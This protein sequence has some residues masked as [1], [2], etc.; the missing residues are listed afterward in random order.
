MAVTTTLNTSYGSQ[1]VVGGGGFFLNNEM[2][3]FSLKPGVRSASGGVGGV[4]NSIEPGKRM[5]S[6]MSPT[7]VLKDG[8]LFMVLGS[9]G[10]TT[11]PTS[12][13]QTIVDIIDFKMTAAD[14]VNEPKFHHEWLPDMISME[15]NFPPKSI[16]ALKAMGYSLNDGSSLGRVELI[17]VRDDS[18]LDIIADNRTSSDSAEG[19]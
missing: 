17:K 7:I 12:V 15:R 18:Y 8:K 19:Y 11:I 9:P 10:G 3:D 5:L 4:A 2:N 13:F 6:S 14:A 16:A 1:V